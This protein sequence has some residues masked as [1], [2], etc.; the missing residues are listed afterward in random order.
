MLKALGRTPTTSYGSP[1]SRTV[2]PTIADR[3]ANRRVH[4]ACPSTTRWCWPGC[5]S[6]GRT[7]RPDHR[8][9]AQ[10]LKE[11]RAT[12]G[13]R[14]PA[15]GSSTPDRFGSHH[16]IRRQL[17][18]GLRLRAATRGNR[19]AVT[20]SRSRNRRVSVIASRR[21]AAD[22]RRRSGTDAGR[23]A[24]IRLNVVAV[25]GQ[26]ERQREHDHDRQGRTLRDRSP[27]VQRVARQAGRPRSAGLLRRD[28]QPP[29]RRRAAPEQAVR[30]VAAGDAAS[31]AGVPAPG[32]CGAHPRA[33]PGV[34]L[35]QVADHGVAP[36]GVAHDVARSSR[37][38]QSG[39]IT[40]MADDV[41]TAPVWFRGL[42]PCWPGRVHR[43]DG[44]QPAAVTVK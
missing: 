32:A 33:Q 12:P 15:R 11:S 24:S 20:F 38:A 1:S 16:S 39:G 44:L 6:S 17:L 18:D 43:L 35:A 8:R 5:A 25:G 21:R 42:W 10:Q 9:D 26:R 37:S 41:M 22:R 34:F 23:C 4:S 2:R 19:R 31:S 27:R 36:V 29:R 40:G 7:S 28:R 13:S 3:T 30:A 14:A